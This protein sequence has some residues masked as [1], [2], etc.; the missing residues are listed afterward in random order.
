MPFQPKFF[1][2]IILLILGVSFSMSAREPVN[3]TAAIRQLINKGRALKA[4]NEEFA[5]SLFREAVKSADSLKFQDD[6]VTF[7]ILEIAN[8]NVYKGKLDSA[9]RLTLRALKYYSEVGNL[10]EMT[11][12]RIR[13]GDILR[14]NGLYSKGYE[15]FDLAS[16][17]ATKLGDTALL[18]MAYNRYA[19]CYYEDPEMSLDSAE[20]YARLSLDLARQLNLPQRI[21]NNLNILGSIESKRK[22]YDKALRL[23]EEALPILMVES[24]QEQALILANMARNHHLSGNMKMAETLS[25]KALEKAQQYNIPQYIYMACMNLEKLYT[26][27]GDYRMAYYYLKLF[28]DV[29]SKLINQRVLVQ[30][31]DFDYRMEMEKKINENERLEYEQR[32]ISNRF[33]LTL[34]VA[35]LLLL[36]L[37]LTG[38]FVFYQQRQR[39]KIRLINEKLDESNIILR[40]FISILAPDLKSPFN[41]ILGFTQILKEDEAQFNEEHRLAINNLHNAGQSTFR[42]LE[43]LLEWSRLQMGT[44]RPEKREVNLNKLAEETISLLTPAADLKAIRLILHPSEPVILVADPEMVL[45]IIRNLVSNAV[46]FTP[47]GGIIEVTIGKTLQAVKIV[48]KDTGV[49]MDERTM[50]RLFRLDDNFKSKG[51]AGE[52]GT[53]LGLI[54]CKEYV[55]MHGGTI[56]LVSEPQK[57]TTFTVEIPG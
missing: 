5:Q 13:I 30:L 29:E 36:V 12:V 51:T 41:S 3:D 39:K 26:D 47:A 49:G 23:Y 55:E 33:R 19:A 22:N 35:I 34:I 32:I 38:W 1:L 46:K 17:D 43:R 27:M 45:T 15:Y 24:P 56:T 48:I 28:K 16:R 14:S 50:A 21:F 53:G 25:L 4:S 18:C 37:V 11:R 52:T 44:T 31:Q 10:R 7:A 9:I 54:L 20:K 57:G 8:N 40:R 42:L 6:A 2:L